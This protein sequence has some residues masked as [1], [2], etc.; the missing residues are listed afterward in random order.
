MREDFAAAVL[1]LVDRIPAGKVLAYG[2]IAELLGTGGPRQVGAVMARDGGAVPWWRV[3]RANGE[4]PQCHGGRARPH[5]EQERTLLQ[6]RAG[7]TYRVQIRAARWQPG[8]ADM[9]RLESVRA[10][11]SGSATAGPPVPDPK[12]K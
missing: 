4:P 5:Y 11:L 2:D 3:I 10:A 6:V 12:S 1:D 7:G 9:A 8:P